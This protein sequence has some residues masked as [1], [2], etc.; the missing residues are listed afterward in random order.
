M[1]TFVKLIS[2]EHRIFSDK[3]DDEMQKLIETSQADHPPMVV[4]VEPLLELVKDILKHSTTTTSGPIVG[5]AL[6]NLKSKISPTNFEALSKTIHLISCKLSCKC[7][8]E[9][10]EYNSVSPLIKTLSGYSW[11]SKVVLVMAAFAVTYGGF[12]FLLDSNKFWKSLE[13]VKTLIEAMVNLTECVISYCKLFYSGKVPG[14]IIDQSLL[15]ISVYWTLRSVDACLP[16]IFGFLGLGTEYILSK[17][18]DKELSKLRKTLIISLDHLNDQL[19]PYLN[20]IEMKQISEYY[21]EIELIFSGMTITNN[22]EIISKLFDVKIGLNSLVQVSTNQQVSVKVL[23]KK[24]VLLLILAELDVNKED[25]RIL[26]EMYKNTKQVSHQYDLVCLTLGESI[27]SK[28]EEFEKLLV[29][30]NLPWY[31]MNHNYKMNKAVIKYIKEVWQFN[32]NPTLVVLGPEGK[33]VS[34]NAF[35]NIKIWGG[36]DLS[37]TITTEVQLWK[38]ATWGLKFLFQ[39]IYQ[40]TNMLDW[41]NDGRFICLYGGEDMNWIRSF[42]AVASEVA[43]KS[44]ST[45]FEMVYMGAKTQRKRLDNLYSVIKNEKLN[46][47]CWPEVV[48]K[49]WGRLDYMWQ[50]RM[51]MMITSKNTIEEDQIMKEIRSILTYD[52]SSDKGWAIICKGSEILVKARGDIMLECFKQYDFWKVSSGINDFMGVVID[53]VKKQEIKVHCNHLILPFTVANILGEMHCENCPCL[54]EKFI[55]YRCCRD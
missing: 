53:Y 28:R 52:G 46:T 25:I 51:E 5:H 12:F 13:T 18:E 33:V 32:G 35:T 3:D 27:Q 11:E 48:T 6:D 42:T 16:H 43:K 45:A 49:F 4:D 50:S 55:M 34:N 22:L 40:G 20:Y 36:S 8:E 44:T 26:A 9:G 47:N 19:L 54:M 7:T 2:Y 24:N 15:Q 38:Q 31:L 14:L 39:N 29:E 41:I 17:T 23:E 30:E 10:E 1:E 21:H 37:I